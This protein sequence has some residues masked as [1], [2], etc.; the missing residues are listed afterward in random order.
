M[1]I[2]IH[3]RILKYE[4]FLHS[5]PLNVS[6]WDEMEDLPSNGKSIFYNGSSLRTVK[7]LRPSATTKKSI[8]S[9]SKNRDELFGIQNVLVLTRCLPYLAKTTITQ[10]AKVK[11]KHFAIKTVSRVLTLLHHSIVWFHVLHNLRTT[12]KNSLG[13][14]AHYLL[15]NWCVDTNCAWI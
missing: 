1:F 3:A 2:G 12:L 5:P 7:I 13:K 10:V 8:I 9:T 15:F 14:L 4:L 6:E 11:E